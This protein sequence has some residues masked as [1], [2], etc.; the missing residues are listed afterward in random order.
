NRADALE[1]GLRDGERIKLVSRRGEIEARARVDSRG[2]CPRGTV[3]VPFFD[4]QR[5]INRLTLDALDNISKEPDFKKCAVKIVR[6]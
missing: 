5:L 2:Q 3:F 6:A 4:E 1:L